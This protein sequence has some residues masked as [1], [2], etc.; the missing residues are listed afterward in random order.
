MR[1]GFGGT[2]TAISSETAPITATFI[3]TGHF[4]TIGEKHIQQNPLCR[5]FGINRLCRFIGE[6]MSPVFTGSP[7]SSTIAL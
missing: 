6:E 2:Q 4:I 7:F 3:S 1:S 5:C